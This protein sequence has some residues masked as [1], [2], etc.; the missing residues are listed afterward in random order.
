[1]TTCQTSCSSCSLAGS[2]CLLFAIKL[3]GRQAGRHGTA[4]V[5]DRENYAKNVSHRIKFNAISKQGSIS[6]N[7][8]REQPPA[9]SKQPFRT[10]IAHLAHEMN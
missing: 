5:G 10:F 3:H 9:Q 1:M 8:L 6:Q 7:Y 2:P 4:Q